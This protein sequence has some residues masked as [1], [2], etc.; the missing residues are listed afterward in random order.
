MLTSVAPFLSQGLHTIKMSFMSFVALTLV[1][2]IANV[3][4]SGEVV[5]AYTNWANYRAG[6]GKFTTGDVDP[7]L[8]TSIYYR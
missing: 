4:G 1:P 7:T 6:E 2:L 3:D 8:C 5:C